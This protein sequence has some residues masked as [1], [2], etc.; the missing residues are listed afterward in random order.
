M[1]A[2][3]ANGNHDQVDAD[4]VGT[5]HT[6]TVVP[7]GPRRCQLAATGELDL[8]AADQLAAALA[9]QRTS[10]RCFAQLDLSAV[11]FLD[12]ACLG[13]LVE[14]HQRFLA[15]HGTLILTGIRPRIERLL[16]LTSLQQT[17]FTVAATLT[18]PDDTEPVPTAAFSD[19]VGRQRAQQA[20]T[21]QTNRA[22]L[23]QAAGIVM[24]RR[25]CSREQAAQ[26][27]RLLAESTN[28]SLTDVAQ[29]I[30]DSAAPHRPERT[31][32]SGIGPQTGS[33][34][35]PAEGHT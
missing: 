27:L 2:T 19:A 11:T 17:L 4:H 31:P 32:G 13:V 6:I 22:V 16:S 24:C 20:Q 28:R 35:H 34:R 1:I 10:G 26:R 30:V 3:S 29:T 9:E 14:A 7:A 21:A 5:G 12:C 15:A 33:T 18:P 8:A 23:E 25:H